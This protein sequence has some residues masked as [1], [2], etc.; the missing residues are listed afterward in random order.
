MPFDV[1]DEVDGKEDVEGE[2][3]KHPITTKHT[4]TITKIT[5]VRV[6]F[7]FFNVY[8]KFCLSKIIKLDFLTREEKTFQRKGEKK[9]IRE[10][11]GKNTGFIFHSIIKE[12]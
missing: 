4:K 5:E 3:E 2:K 9:W 6:I 7:Y 8:S 12:E 1:V 11:G 10:N